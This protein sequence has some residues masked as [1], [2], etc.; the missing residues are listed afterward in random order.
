MARAKVD[1]EQQY[2][3]SE[4]TARCT[5]DLRLRL[6]GFR[7]KHR[8]PGKPAVWERQIEPGK[9]VDYTEVRAH[10]YADLQEKAVAEA[11]ECL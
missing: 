2:D 11:G 8:P 7:I 6:H 1:L 5:G 10:K 3:T 4:T 9:W